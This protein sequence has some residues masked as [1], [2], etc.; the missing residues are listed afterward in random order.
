MS[1]GFGSFEP[2]PAWPSVTTE[3][4]VTG[5]PPA[6][7]EMQPAPLAAAPSQQP[8]PPA[9]TY[10]AL[11]PGPDPRFAEV[12][13]I[14][15]S[16]V[17]D[18][19]G[20]LSFNPRAPLPPLPPPPMQPMPGNLRAPMPRGLGDDTP[21]SASNLLGLAL[22]AVPVAAAVG[23]KYA[24]LL[25]LL[26]GALLGGAAVNSVRAA[27]NFMDGTSDSDRE[28]T[29]SGTYA[30]VGAAAGAYLVYQGQKK[31]EPKT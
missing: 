15:A 12:D 13:R 5:M 1:D 30:V 4:A 7:F 2:P 29:V 10:A 23:A 22:L 14:P 19:S 11:P 27:K 24:G 21:E 17:V 31:P 26:G 28:A 8:A 3:G 18:V 9:Q 16:N 6:P 20:G 25:G